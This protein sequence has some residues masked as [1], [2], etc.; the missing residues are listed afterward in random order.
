M[1]RRVVAV[2][3]GGLAVIGVVTGVLVSEDAGPPPL[4]NPATWSSGIEC[5]PGTTLADGFY[6]IENPSDEA[7]TITSVHLVGGSGQAMTSPAWLVPWNSNS[8]PLIGLNPPWPP[9]APWWKP[10]WKQRY[11]AVGATVPAHGSAELVFRQNRTDAHPT[12][13]E[14]EFTY[15]AGGGTWTVVERWQTIIIPGSSCVGYQWQ[16][17]ASYP[18]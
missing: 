8:H 2:A 7:V 14:A 9:D 15:T 6:V 11:L 17:P 3:V 1:R 16:P 12:P 4:G 13:A 5:S 18:S 10:W